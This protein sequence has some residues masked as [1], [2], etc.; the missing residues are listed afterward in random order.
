MTPAERARQWGLL[1]INATK[2]VRRMQHDAEDNGC[3]DLARRI[4]EREDAIVSLL[5]RKEPE[6]PTGEP[7]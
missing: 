2:H 7:R 3:P 5:C 4:E 6:G 1:R